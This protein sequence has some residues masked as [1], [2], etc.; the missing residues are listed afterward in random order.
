MGP[1]LP[2]IGQAEHVP[3][4]TGPGLSKPCLDANRRLRQFRVLSFVP[5]FAKG[6]ETAIFGIAQLGPIRSIPAALIGQ[7]LIDAPDGGRL[8]AQE[9]C[10]VFVRQVSEGFG[11][12][13]PWVPHDC[14]SEACKGG[15]QGM[16]NEEGWKEA[17][18]TGL[19]GGGQKGLTP[20]TF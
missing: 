9:L 8:D 4:C 13:D 5:I 18:G 20:K 7:D 15:G 12:V 17:V 2:K 3:L 1:K 14:V 11:L 16:G 10:V 6:P 19:G